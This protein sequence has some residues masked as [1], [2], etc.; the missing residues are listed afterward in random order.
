MAKKLKMPDIF[1]RWKKWHFKYGHGYR[2][3]VTVWAQDETEAYLKG[4][5]VLVKRFEESGKILPEQTLLQL[6]WAAKD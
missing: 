6:V 5:R 4:R 3:T 2:E 1:W